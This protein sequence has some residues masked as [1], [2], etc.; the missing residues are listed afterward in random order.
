MDAQR[1]GRQRQWTRGGVGPR[2]D[3]PIA[4]DDGANDHDNAALSYRGGVGRRYKD[5]ANYE[6]NDA[7]HHW[8]MSLMPL[9]PPPLPLPLPLHPPP[10]DLSMSS[11]TTQ[12]VATANGNGIVGTFFLPTVAG[13]ATSSFVHLNDNRG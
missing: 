8:A 3:A 12:E 6:D 7:S 4:N 1:R 9:R 11:L 13:R 5:D 10:T 2:N